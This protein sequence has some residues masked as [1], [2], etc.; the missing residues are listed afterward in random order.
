MNFLEKFSYVQSLF[1]DNFI[2][3]LN[4][5][6]FWKKK[7]SFVSNNKQTR[8]IFWMQISAILAWQPKY[9]DK[10][11][12][13]I[14]AYYKEKKVVSVKTKKDLN[15]LQDGDDCDVEDGCLTK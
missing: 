3:S 11:K 4:L 10:E 5:L 14:D 6:I 8:Q 7:I 2:K 13:D 1:D 12:Y 9:S 15:N